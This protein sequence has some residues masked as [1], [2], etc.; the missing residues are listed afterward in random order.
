VYKISVKNC[1]IGKWKLYCMP[2]WIL[3]LLTYLVAHHFIR[4]KN[5]SKVKGYHILWTTFSSLK[6]LYSTDLSLC[7][8]GKRKL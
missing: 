8:W 1:I 2:F 6:M 5:I 3:Y 7:W 4:R